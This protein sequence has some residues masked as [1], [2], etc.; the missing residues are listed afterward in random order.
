MIAQQP[1]VLIVDD[2]RNTRE[3][4][5]RGLSPVQHEL[6]LSVCGGRG[7]QSRKTPAELLAVGDPK[8]HATRDLIVQ[9]KS[10][11]AAR[12]GSKSKKKAA[13]ARSNQKATTKK[14]AGKSKSTRKT[15]AKAS[16]GKK[17]KASKTTRK[18][19]ARKGAGKAKAGRKTKTPARRRAAAARSG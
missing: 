18:S 19:S 17:A 5:K 6:G 15:K 2:D 13:K 14:T 10:G 12:G 3:S 4:L 8:K 1:S 11:K 16:G 9:V 7:R